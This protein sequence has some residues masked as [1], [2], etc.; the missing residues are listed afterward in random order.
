MENRSVKRFYFIVLVMILLDTVSVQA[1][2]ADDHWIMVVDLE[3]HW[4]FSIGDNK[5]WAEPNYIDKDWENIDVPAKWEDEGFYG[6][7]GYAWYRK[8][9]DG[10]SLKNKNGSYNLFLGY[11]DD[12][13]EVYFNGHKIGAS[14]SFP[15]RYETAYNALRNY[16][17]PNEYIN[18]L[19]RNVIAVRVYDAEIEGGIVSGEIGI[20]TNK[21]DAALV[22]NL[23]G[24]WDFKLGDRK[25]GHRFSSDYDAN[26]KRTPPEKG[27]W[28]KMA[29]PS[30]WEN[31]G[32]N[33]HDGSAWYRKQFIIPKD[34]QGEDLVLILGKIDDYDQTYFNGK[35]IGSTNQY[36][37][38]RIY[39]ISSDMYSA[40]ALNILLVY[41]DDPQGLGGIYEGPIGIMKQ[42]SFTR[43]MRYRD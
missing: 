26:E 2:V 6:Y 37:K 5:K 1:K 16:Y 12:V 41:V 4:K 9:F 29:V 38:L 23:R 42:S 36:D 25:F 39:H 19:G 40:G 17:I 3:D 14:G 43:Y 21:D 33:D 18:Y 22:V 15:P 32:Y 11:I 24:M 34:I 28:I 27:S 8:A 10:T 31:Q 7:N 30:Y 35:V 20:F 13:D